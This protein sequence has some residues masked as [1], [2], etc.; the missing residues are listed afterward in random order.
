M[1]SSIADALHLYINELSKDIQRISVDWNGS[2]EAQLSALISSFATFVKRF[3]LPIKQIGKI[4]MEKIPTFLN[5]KA[6][7]KKNSSSSTRGHSFIDC[8]FLNP[9]LVCAKCGYL[10][11][12]IGYQGIIC[13]SKK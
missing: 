7:L 4:D 9:K 2:N 3:N 8:S 12:G 5:K 13:Q 11:W 6:K 1:K 10:F